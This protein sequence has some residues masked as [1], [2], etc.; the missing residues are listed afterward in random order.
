MKLRSLALFSALLVASVAAHAQS[1]AYAM[2]DAQQFTRNGLYVAPPSG[3]SN[4]ESP[5]LYGTTFGAYYTITRLPFV[6]KLPTGPVAVGLD[7]RGTI[8]R[9]NSQYSRDEAIVSLRLSTKAP[10]MNLTPYVQGGAGL[11][12]TKV[13]GQLNFTNNWNYDFAVGADRRLTKLLSVRV[14]VSG[15]FMANYVAGTNVNNSNHLLN[16]AGG[17][18]IHI[19]GRTP[20]APAGH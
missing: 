2:F 14:E 6:P 4:S 20:A 19:P 7:G 8:V 15:G 10:V 13:P 3:V 12:H 18:L 16:F 1:A 5:W 11:G 17:L 9:T